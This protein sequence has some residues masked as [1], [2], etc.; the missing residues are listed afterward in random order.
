MRYDGAMLPEGATPTTVRMFPDYADTVL[1]LVY[2]VDYEDTDLSPGLIRELEA[3][4]RSYYEALDADFNWKS[5]ELARAFTKTG[6]DL[7]GRVANEL[8]EEFVIEFASYET[9]APTYTVH[10]RRPADNEGASTA[11]STIAEELEAEQKRVTQLVAEAGP[12]AE[13]TAYAPLSGD[14]F[15][16]GRKAPQAEDRD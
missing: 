12:D 3:W 11:F 4:E 14:V 15:T 6:I 9:T 7:A 10:S 8:G 5:P 16:W 2:P 13:W 1:W